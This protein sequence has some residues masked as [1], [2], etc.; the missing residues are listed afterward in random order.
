VTQ[1]FYWTQIEECPRA[2]H[3][4]SASYTIT[5]TARNGYITFN[6]ETDQFAGRDDIESIAVGTCTVNELDEVTNE[7]TSGT[8]PNEV[9]VG[10]FKGM[11][12]SYSAEEN[13]EHKS[14]SNEGRTTWHDWISRIETMPCILEV[15]RDAV[16]VYAG[17]GGHTYGRL[18]DGSDY[19]WAITSGSDK[20]RVGPRYSDGQTAEIEVFGKSASTNDITVRGTYVGEDGAQRSC[21]A[22][23]TGLRPSQLQVL[24]DV[25]VPLHQEGDRWSVGVRRKY[26]VLDQ[27]GD[28]IR[29]EA[30]EVTEQLSGIDPLGNRV[31]W[32]TG[33]QDLSF[34]PND[35]T[36]VGPGA[37]VVTI[38]AQRSHTNADGEFD[39]TVHIWRIGLTFPDQ[40]NFLVDQDIFVDGAPVG[41]F[42]L[43]FL[44]TSAAVNPR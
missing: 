39:D 31:T 24:E 2:T 41:Q 5:G 34:N 27:F 1:G 6:V 40:T 28:P 43:H 9:T 23:I 17:H 26:R 21:T 32:S 19:Q 7:R 25:A 22:F 10:H 14:T 38:D 35:I 15:T 36:L 4:E 18:P 12:R 11:H 8:K 33:G 42:V 44:S 16:L 29:E 37:P 30:L 13:W 3:S 20:A